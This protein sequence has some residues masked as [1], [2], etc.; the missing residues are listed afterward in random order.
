MFTLFP[1][2]SPL[3]RDSSF[4]LFPL[5]IALQFSSFILFTPE[6]LLY[7]LSILICL[8]FFLCFF[9]NFFF[10]SYSFLSYPVPLPVLFLP[11][12]LI[13]HPSLKLSCPIRSLSS[14]HPPHPPHLLFPL[15]PYY[16]SLLFSLSFPSFILSPQTK[17]SSSS[18]RICFMIF[19]YALFPI[20][21]LLIKEKYMTC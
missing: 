6:Y 14:F 19:L 5:H 20:L 12:V 17:P 1:F 11:P 8:F 10:S 16:L 4:F 3:F 2:A 7:F 18:L 13:H 15:S 21:T 9:F